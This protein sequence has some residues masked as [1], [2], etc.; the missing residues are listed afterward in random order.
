M[1]LNLCGL[2]L[3]VHPVGLL[4][5]RD[6][7]ARGRDALSRVREVP[8]AEPVVPG[9]NTFHIE[10]PKD[11]SQVPEEGAVFPVARR[12][13]EHH[14]VPEGGHGVRD[15]GGAHLQQQRGGGLPALRVS[16]V[17]S[18]GIHLPGAL[19]PQR[20]QRANAHQNHCSGEACTQ[21]RQIHLL[22]GRNS[23]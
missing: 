11:L 21:V 15:P 23:R 3:D 20:R 9:Q 16:S 8:P 1:D 14:E 13:K 18:Q 4:T 10:V 7:G 2:V 12:L 6:E 19:A 5:V 17:Q 22:V